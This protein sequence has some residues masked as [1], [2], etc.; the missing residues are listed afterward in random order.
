[1]AYET[2]TRSIVRIEEPAIALEPQGRL[3]LNAAC[4]RLLEA[5]GVKAVNL[6]WD[7]TKYGLALQAV[8]KGDKNSYSIAFSRGR[9]ALITAR[10]FFRYIGWSA[11][12]RVTVPARWDSKLRMIEAEI[13][14]RFLKAT[15]RAT[16]NKITIQDPT[17]ETS[18]IREYLQ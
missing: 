11:K 9:S 14:S 4:T 7:K 2:F 18:L 10:A 6:L 8:G 13:P 5:G 1:L 3:A 15:P 16:K 17:I 12:Q